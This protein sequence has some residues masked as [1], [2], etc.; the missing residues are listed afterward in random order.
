MSL[1]TNLYAA[2]SGLCDRV[3]PDIA[4]NNTSLPY[5]TWSQVGGDVLQ[6]LA[7]Q[8]ADKRNARVQVNVWAKTRAEA[9]E[10]MLDSEQALIESEDFIAVQQGAAVSSYSE[11]DDIRGMFQ[12]FS[13]WADR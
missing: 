8:L 7:N 1:E 6:P 4:P 5:I 2:L 3:Y 13:I 10:L 9:V 11:D 12:L